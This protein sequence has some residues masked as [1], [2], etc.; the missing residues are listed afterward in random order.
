MCGLESLFMVMD[1]RKFLKV[2][3]KD[4]YVTFLCVYVCVCVGMEGRWARADPEIF[5][6]GGEVLYVG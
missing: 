3:W 6:K 5:K 4:K 1:L 2:A